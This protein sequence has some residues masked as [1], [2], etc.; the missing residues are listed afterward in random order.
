MRNELVPGRIVKYIQPLNEVSFNGSKH[1]PA[2]IT[3]VWSDNCVNL[4]VFPDANAP[5][6]ATSVN[7]NWEPEKLNELNPEFQFPPEW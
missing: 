7:R 2:M 4:V 1:H 6:T 5:F 3:R